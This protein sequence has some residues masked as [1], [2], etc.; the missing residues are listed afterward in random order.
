MIKLALIALMGVVALTGAARVRSPQARAIVPASYTVTGAGAPA[1][2]GLSDGTGRESLSV[3]YTPLDSTEV[4]RL[5]G[6]GKAYHMAVVYTDA[7]GRSFGASSGPSDLAAPQTPGGAL[8]ALVA[9]AV[10]APSTFGTLVADPH[11]GTAFVKGDRAD[12]Y[13]KDSHGHAYPSAVVARGADLSA[14]WAAIVRTY[15]RVGAM[16]LTYSPISQNSNSLATTALRDAG[17]GLPFSSAT[18]FVPGSLT[19]LPKG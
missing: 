5:V 4:S 14:R 6:F 11:N 10:D 9:M 8:S 3:Y 19:R 7:A 17:I 12:Y 1:G 16:G 13:T 15:A 18:L 2:N